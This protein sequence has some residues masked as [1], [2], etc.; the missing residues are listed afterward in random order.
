[1]SQLVRSCKVPVPVAPATSVPVVIITMMS[2]SISLLLTLISEGGFEV[3]PWDLVIYT[4][5]GVVIS[6]LILQQ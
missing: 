4:A 2:A 1:M 6:W 3:I 5:P